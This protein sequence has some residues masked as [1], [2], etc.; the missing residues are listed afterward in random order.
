MRVILFNGPLAEKS[1]ALHSTDHKNGSK[2]VML[3][4]HS[5]EKKCVL[6][7][8]SDRTYKYLFVLHHLSQIL[9]VLE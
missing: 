6:S 4:L 5:R 7:L 2:A 3:E 9:I 1:G 8:S